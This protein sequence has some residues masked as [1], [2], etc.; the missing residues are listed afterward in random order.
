MSTNNIVYKITHWETWDWRIKYIPIL[1]LWFWHC[2][3]SRSFWFFTASNPRLAFGGFDGETK[4]SVYDHL[5]PASYPKSVLI[6]PELAYAEVENEVR[7]KFKY[8]FI[9]KPDVGRM[10]LMFRIIGNSTELQLYHKAMSVNYI[11]QEL[12][13]YPVEVSVF[14]YRFPNTKSGTIT[15]LIRKEFMEVVGDG[16]STLVELMIAYPRI[17]FRL[18]EMKAKHSEKLQYVL[19]KGE[20]FCLSYA[21]NLSRGGKLVNIE[22]EKDERLLKLFDDLS[23]YSGTF[24]YGRY[25]IKCTSVDD[26]KQ[27]KNFSILEY[28]GAGAEPHHVYGNGYTLLEACKILSDHWSVLYRISKCNKSLGINYWNFNQGRQRMRECKKH[29]SAL[30]KADLRLPVF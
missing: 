18:E 6:S 9:V 10:G 7:N 14:Y 11:V 5:P 29:F 26:L 30:R 16:Q 2:L 28:N 3:R 4:M 20:I 19:N 21:L 23:N 17:R 12:I 27:G 8:P 15:G 22:H 25:D 24:Y 1:P 13:D